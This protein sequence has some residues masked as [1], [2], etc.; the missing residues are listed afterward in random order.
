MLPIKE[1]LPS[2]TL[3]GIL[4]SGT[5]NIQKDLHLLP[6]Y[7]THYVFIENKIADF[8]R[9]ANAFRVSPFSESY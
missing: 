8:K 5:K 4:F 1:N 2:C 6:F 9:A 3:T 7:P